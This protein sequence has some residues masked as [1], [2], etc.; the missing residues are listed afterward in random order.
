MSKD[1][2]NTAQQKYIIS[3]GVYGFH[4]YIGGKTLE[5]LQMAQIMHLIFAPGCSSFST[6]VRMV[7]FCYSYTP[8]NFHRLDSCYN[9]M[10]RL[11]QKWSC[12][13]YVYLSILNFTLFAP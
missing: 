12:L 2:I 8:D 1:L 3:K 4:W 5:N 13:Q 11:M 6:L 10:R 7:D 9:L